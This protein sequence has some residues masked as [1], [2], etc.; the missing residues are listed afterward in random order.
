MDIMYVMDAMDTIQELK[1]EDE[2][3]SEDEVLGFIILRHVNNDL[4]NKYWIHC[5]ECIRRFYP[6]NPIL[7]IDDN[8]H[9]SFISEAEESSLYKTRIIRS[10]YPKRGELLPYHY[11][12]RN[13]FAD[14]AVILHDSVFIHTYIDFLSNTAAYKFIW[15]FEHYWDQIE[16]ETKMIRLLQAAGE[17]QA[18]GELLSFYENKALWKGCFGAMSVIRHEFLQAVDAKYEFTTKL[19][20]CVKERYNRCSFE[21]VVA[22]IFQKEAAQTTLLG[23]IHDYMPWGITFDSRQNFCHLPI[24]KVWT[25]R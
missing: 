17:K 14:A 12:L 10:E 7:I 5:Y 24:I 4:T 16:D 3:E 2:S 20:D 25:G 15:H 18:A 8:S 6:E 19:L 22:C 13:K 21:R 23:K 9:Y 11:Y 1:D